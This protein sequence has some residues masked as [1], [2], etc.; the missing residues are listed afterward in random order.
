MA[1]KFPLAV[2]LKYRQ[3]I[4]QREERALLKCREAVAMLQTQLAE[5]K[6]QRERLRVRQ[7]ETLAAGVLGDDLHY[8]AEQER[9]LDQIEEQLQRELSAA[10]ADFDNQMKVFLAARQKREI[11]DALKKSQH[12]KY[13]EEEDRREQSRVDELFNARLRPNK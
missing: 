10:V 8:A 3:E 9:S 6:A 12:K 4:E 7:E 2:V 1:F 11:L 13:V 5:L